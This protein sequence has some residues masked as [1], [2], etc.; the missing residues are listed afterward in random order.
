MPEIPDPD[1]D[2]MNKYLRFQRS[3][4]AEVGKK[5]QVWCVYKMGSG[6]LLGEIKWYGPWRQYVFFPS[7]QTLFNADCLTSIGSVCLDLTR[8]WRAKK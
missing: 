4:A 3:P 5:T 1:Y 8:R 2:D 6:F 7:Q